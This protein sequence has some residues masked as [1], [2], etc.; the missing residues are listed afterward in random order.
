MKI[1]LAQ[2]NPIVG[3]IEGNANKIISIVKKIS[4]DIVVFPELSVTGYSP[5]DLLL[6]RGFIRENENAL[7]RIAGSVKNKTAIVGFAENKNNKLYNSAAVIKNKKIIKIHRKI[8]LPN[9]AI[10][11]EK[12]WFEAGNEATIFEFEGKKIGIS[13]CEDIWHPKV[14]KKQKENGTELIINIS[15]SPYRKGKFEAIEN[16]LKQRW[17][18]NKIPII[19]VNQA[20]GQDGIVFYGRS[21]HFKGGKIMKK[22]R[23][24][25]EEVLVVDV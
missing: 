21:M 17:N 23:D 1:A 7:G 24:F 9:Y 8:C 22:C 12:R 10:F 2:I 4:A 20:G 15:A 25:E 11:D 13:I 5:Q 16:I 14:S 18:E 3:D 19:Y 6:R